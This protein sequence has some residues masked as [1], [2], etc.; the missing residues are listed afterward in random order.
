VAT[1]PEKTA[2]QLERERVAV[3]AMANAK[4]NMTAALDRIQT[5]ERALS[6]AKHSI[7]VLKGYVAPSAYTYPVNGTSRL[8]TAT[9]DDA[10]AAI[11]KVLN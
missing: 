2:E 1:E 9:A 6:S 7:G 3:A 5:L 10:I 8:C 11:S 4:S